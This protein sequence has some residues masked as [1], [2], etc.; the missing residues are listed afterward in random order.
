MLLIIAQSTAP[1]Q[2]VPSDML[3]TIAAVG[4]LLLG[5]VNLGYLL[6][7]EVFRKARIVVIIESAIARARRDG[8]IDTQISLRISARNQGIYITDMWLQYKTAVLGEYEPT[9][10][11]D[12]NRALGY[13]KRNLLDLGENDFE[14]AVRESMKTPVAVR[15]LHIAELE[16]RSLTFADRLITERLPDQY[17]EFPKKGWSLHVTY[18]ERHDILPIIFAVHPKSTPGSISSL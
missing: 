18:G 14:V 13:T 6:Y 15:D 8:T 5:L 7:K 4:G 1:I 9:D 16:S 11:M 17:M 3:K 10:R 12:L 2:D